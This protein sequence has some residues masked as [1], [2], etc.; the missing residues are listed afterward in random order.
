MIQ[1]SAN[2][3]LLQLLLLLSSEVLGYLTFSIKIAK[4]AIGD[5]YRILL[6]R[7]LGLVL[8][9]LVGRPPFLCSLYNAA[10]TVSQCS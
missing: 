2:F 3:A 10:L 9:Y 1:P 4:W 5:T 8:A 7:F 6:Q